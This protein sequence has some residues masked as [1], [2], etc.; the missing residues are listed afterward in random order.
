MISETHSSLIPLGPARVDLA[1]LPSRW[2]ELRGKHRT[3]YDYLIMARTDPHASDRACL[4]AVIPALEA[5]HTGYMV[6]QR[7]S[8][9]R[10]VATRSSTASTRCASMS[11][12]GAG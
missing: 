9:A 10:S 11:A 1:M 5:L 6:L 7:Q 3:F 12:I 8:P 2:R 4:M